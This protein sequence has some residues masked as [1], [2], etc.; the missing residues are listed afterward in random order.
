MIALPDY[1]EVD[2]STWFG[3]LAEGSHM[4]FRFGQQAAYAFVF[5]SGY[6]IAPIL[7]NIAFSSSSTSPL[8][9][10]S[11][12]IL[13][14]YP[15][16]LAAILLTATCDYLGIVVLMDAQI[17]RETLDYDPVAALNWHAALGNM[18]SLQ[19]TFSGAFGSN[20]PL[21][22]LGYLVQFYLSGL[23]LAYGLRR[24]A[25][26]TLI[27]SGLI[28]VIVAWS[29]PEW[30]LLFLT[31][32]SAGAVRYMRL[33][34]LSVAWLSLPG[35]LVFVAANLV[36]PLASIP[37][38]AFASTLFALSFRSNGAAFESLY[39]RIFSSVDAVSYAIYAFH[40]PV[41]LLTFSV[42][43]SNLGTGEVTRI[44][45]FPI[46]LFVVVSI[47]VAWSFVPKSSPPSRDAS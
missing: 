20:G 31:W 21:W 46:S 22:T 43:A 32:L 24:H 2:S 41:A 12:R 27:Y 29:R 28:L 18:L 25:L 13:R 33:P 45:F 9:F 23:L 15:T 16:L 4:L 6:F 14:I 1:G 40:F 26:I 42:L 3:A 38:V 11:Q 19:P 34:A 5:L 39:L 35:L 7:V 8:K 47:A 36:P 10:L 30:I 37:M 17:Y 44:V